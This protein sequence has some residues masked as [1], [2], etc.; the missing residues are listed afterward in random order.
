MEKAI[1]NL[2][3]KLLLE[4]V[5]SRQWTEA[6]PC[7]LGYCCIIAESHRQ[8]SHVQYRDF[9]SWLFW[10][11]CLPS[12]LRGQNFHLRKIYEASTNKV[13]P[14]ISPDSFFLK[15]I[16]SIHSSAGLSLLAPALR[17]CLNTKPWVLARAA[18]SSARHSSP[19]CCY[20]PDWCW[21]R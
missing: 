13:S 19:V 12:N 10:F 2:K 21:L 9:T 6:V 7:N 14:V 4:A 1:R 17:V 11:F 5:E 15:I 16:T 20:L 3:L 18:S 8:P